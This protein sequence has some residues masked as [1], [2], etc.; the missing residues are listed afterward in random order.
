MACVR[1]GLLLSRDKGHVL[2]V[3]WIYLE[4]I[5]LRQAWQRK[6]NTKGSHLHV[7]SGWG[8]GGEPNW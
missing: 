8:V 2:A 6:K 5:M 4:D 3:T 7:E 1:S